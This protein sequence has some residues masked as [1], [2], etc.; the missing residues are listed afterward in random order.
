V[1]VRTAESFDQLLS[2]TP[3]ETQDTY[4]HIVPAKMG[5]NEYREASQKALSFIFCI[6]EFMSAYNGAAELEAKFWAV[7]SSI[8]HP[9]VEGLNDSQLAEM[10]CRTRASLS[11]HIL[12]FERRNGILSAC[13]VHCSQLLTMTS[14]FGEPSA[15]YRGGFFFAP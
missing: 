10:L 7:A 12:D 3:D 1:D 4:D 6:V 15:R 9:A 14:L 13:L 8:E 2:C 11:K 5:P